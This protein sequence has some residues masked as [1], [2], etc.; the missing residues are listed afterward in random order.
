MSTEPGALGGQ[1]LPDAIKGPAASACTA[2]SWAGN[3]VRPRRGALPGC[4][5]G[6]NCRLASVTPASLDPRSSW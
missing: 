5:A 6:S 2:L 1:V 3:L 4:A